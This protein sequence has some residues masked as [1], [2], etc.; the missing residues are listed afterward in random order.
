MIAAVNW[1][2]IIGILVNRMN[3]CIFSMEKYLV[4]KGGSYFPTL[5][6]LLVTVGIICIGV[7]LFIGDKM[8]SK[9]YEETRKSVEFVIKGSKKMWDKYF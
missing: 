8:K 3:V 4:S 6:E 2:V 5:Q 7:F 1:M 9:E